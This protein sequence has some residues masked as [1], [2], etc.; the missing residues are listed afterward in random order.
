MSSVFR[1]FFNSVL[2]FGF[3]PVVS[4]LIIIFYFQQISKKEI[5]SNYQK[6]C[7]I[8]AVVSY[9]NINN[10][11]KRLEYLSYLKTVYSDEKIFLRSVIERY[12]E[13]IFAAILDGNGIER[14]RIA[15]N[16]ISRN[17]AIIDI[18]KEDYFKKL[19]IGKEGVIGNFTI[20]AGYPLATVIYPV[21][22]DFVYTILNLKDFFSN[23]YLTRIGE[24]GFVVYISDDGKLLSDK[25]FRLPYDDILK[26]ISDVSGSIVTSINKEKYLLVFRKVGEFEFYV[27]LIQSYKEMF[28]NINILFYLALFL[29][30]LILTISYF[31]SYISAKNLT[32]PITAVVEQ[33]YKISEG[34]F[35]GR[36]N[37]KSNF[38][39]M[40]TLIEVFNN[41]ISKL[42]EYENIHIEKIMDEREKLNVIMHNIKNGVALTNLSGEVIYMNSA[43]KVIIGD[44]D[45]RD[46]FHNL[47]NMSSYEKSRIFENNGM[48]YE[49]TYDILKLQRGSPILLFVIEDITAEM[50]IYKTK[51]EIFK[52]IV[53]DVRTP[54]LNMQGYI[55]LLSYGADEKIKKYISGLETE[56]AI[57]FRMLENILDMA[58]IEN[59]TLYLNKTRINIIEFLSKLSDRFIARAEFK[60]IEFR[61]VKTIEQSYVD[62]DEELFQRAI[63]NLLSNAF[64]YT[65]SG[66]KVVMGVERVGERI[67]IYVK[68]TGKGI[69]KERI[70]H[71][72]E[73]FRSSSKDGFGLGLSITKAIVEMHEGV[74]EV[75]SEEG[76]GTE[77]RIFINEVK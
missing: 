66:G 42:Q 65:P 10:F 22:S 52:S 51:E 24:S 76:K 32:D 48:Y 16:S 43:C 63:D 37:I 12:P 62:I 3:L 38:K 75:E 44:K 68:D 77:V 23:I 34:D 60:N 11:A 41:M 35:S 30:F 72:F 54:L 2:L 15:V 40:N 19:K 18:S 47:V 55:K 6:L 14:K 67:K 69:D 46:F 50:N 4:V 13:V 26:I 49:F 31:V 73:K 28:R 61:F 33:S 71:L 64:K 70:K 25:N 27:A 58:R 56:S 9:E 59:K 8:F 39:E 45:S 7:D 1:R 36:V 57:I 21:G 29:I 5:I 53:H 17:I 74:I 20:K